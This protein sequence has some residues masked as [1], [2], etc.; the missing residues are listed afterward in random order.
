[1]ELICDGSTVC[2]GCAVKEITRKHT[3]WECLASNIST[4]NHLRQKA[5]DGLRKPVISTASTKSKSKTFS[6]REEKA[7]L[8]NLLD[9]FDNQDLSPLVQRFEDLKISRN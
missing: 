7:R 5:K 9:F 8:K 6:A 3:C 4:T 2:W 1:M